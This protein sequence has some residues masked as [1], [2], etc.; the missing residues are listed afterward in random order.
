[1]A[2][3]RYPNCRV[4]SATSMYAIQ[5]DDGA[6]VFFDDAGNSQARQAMSS[7][8]LHKAPASGVT[9]S[10]DDTRVTVSGSSTG[11]TVHVTTIRPAQ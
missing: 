8:G 11:N 2:A 4:T 6:V 10:N 1:M 3:S 9:T 5:T 7:G